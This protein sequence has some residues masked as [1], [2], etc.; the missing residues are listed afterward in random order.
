MET[1]PR[2]LTNQGSGTCGSDHI[3]VSVRLNVVAPGTSGSSALCD[4]K[5]RS[6]SAIRR[7]IGTSDANLSS[8][9]IVR[10]VI[11]HPNPKDVVLKFNGI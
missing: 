1:L 6:P 8:F 2:T 10:V 11:I 9:R 4:L 7:E 5:Y 3:S